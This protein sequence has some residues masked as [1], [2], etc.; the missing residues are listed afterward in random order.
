MRNIQVAT[1]RS[2]EEFMATLVPNVEARAVT[3]SPVSQETSV[4]LE[5]VLLTASTSAS[6]GERQ[7]SARGQVMARSKLSQTTK[8]LTGHIDTDINVRVTS[9]YAESSIE[10]KNTG[11]GAADIFLAMCSC[12]FTRR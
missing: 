3:V 1:R 9:A 7:A 6:A 8:V 12:F 11:R 10:K 5:E 4:T 2:E